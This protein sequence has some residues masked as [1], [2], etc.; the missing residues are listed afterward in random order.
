VIYKIIVA[1]LGTGLLIWAAIVDSRTRKI[2]VAAGFGMLGLGLVVLLWESWYLW[3]AYYVLAIWCTRG[4][5]WKMVLVVASLGMLLI[6]GWEAAPMVA[7]ILF[8]SFL[9]WQKWFGGG[10]SQLAFGLIGIGHDWIV[11]AILFGLTI[12][13]GVL[14][15][16]IRRGGIRQGVERLAS[17]ARRIGEEP[18]SEAIRTPWGIVAAVAGV[19][20]LWLWAL[21]L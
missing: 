19:S 21:V 16:I 12:I 5:I 11:L 17:I 3:A 8:V 18:D 6:E 15:T 4:G 7:G 1:A 9:F 10:D 20:Y 2:P 13:F 14:M